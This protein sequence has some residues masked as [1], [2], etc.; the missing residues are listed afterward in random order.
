[1]KK[2]L[3]KLFSLLPLKK[4]K[5]IFWSY[6]GAQYGCN[7]KYI[8][9]FIVNHYPEYD[10]V[11]AISDPGLI[12]NHKVRK[13][14]YGSI[15][16][17]LELATAQIIITNYRLGLDIEKR[18]KQIYV[19]T[20]HSSIRLKKIEKDAEKFIPV[21]Y[22]K[23]AKIDSSKI[24]FLL[25]GCEH[26]TKIFRESFWYNGEILDIGTPRIDPI[27]NKNIVK[28][29]EIKES[30]GLYADDKVLLYAPTFRNNNDYSCY[31]SDFSEITAALETKMGGD[32]KVL[33][34]LHPHLINKSGEIIKNKTAIDVSKY[35]DI[36]ELLMITDFLI[37][38]YSSLMF[39]FLYSKKPVA[40]FLPDLEDYQKNERELYYNIEELPFLKGIDANGLINEIINFDEEKYH[41][42][43]T[44]FIEKIGSFEK[45]NTSKELVLIL[46]KHLE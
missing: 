15:K 28:I 31:L 44:S 21:N 35:F 27:I 9:E 14:K 8:S 40:L 23:Q 16:F 46:K 37:T 7:P 1:M 29:N 38:D 22:I 3:Y 42:G 10:V 5:I 13:V 33:V 20:W 6:Y 36:Q 24:D 43:L 12:S 45:G 11:W 25:S 41:L 34:R 2:L 39:D 4:N 17:L 19:Q 18:K 26:S 30:L 32:W